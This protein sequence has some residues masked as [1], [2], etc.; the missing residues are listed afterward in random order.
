MAQIDTDLVFIYR[1]MVWIEEAVPAWYRDIQEFPPDEVICSTMEALC[2]NSFERVGAAL[3]IL[4]KDFDLY[5][6]KEISADV[7]PHEPAGAGTC[8]SL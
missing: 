4:G 2:P 7:P 6:V 3:T 5:K 1:C 8:R